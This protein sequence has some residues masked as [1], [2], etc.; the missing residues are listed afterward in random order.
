VRS[1]VKQ[2]LLYVLRVESHDRAL[3][4]IIA[5]NLF[6]LATVYFTDGGLILLLWPYWAQSV[7]IGYYARK[8]MLALE[9][10]STAGL[11]MNDEPIPATKDGARS[12]AN[13]FTMHYGFFHF[14]YFVFL[15]VFT[16]TSNDA[17][18]VP[19]TVNGEPKEVFV[20]TLDA[21][22]ALLIAAIALSFAHAHQITHREQVAMDAGANRNLGG[23]MA[24]PYLRVVPMHLTIIL[25]LVLGKG[26]GLL[27][28]GG[29]KT[30]ADVGM[31]LVERHWLK[32]R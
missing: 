10:F 12:T 28:F 29:L 5:G 7:V 32:G 6:A 27:L 19:V 25:G 13:F 21:L 16:T 24:F 9:T 4:W 2:Q 30:L 17:G 8:R 3:P 22:D 1:V 14:V 31:H 20:G 26:A 23:L 18:L 15:M 11:Q